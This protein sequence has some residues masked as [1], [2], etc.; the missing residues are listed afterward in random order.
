MGENEISEIIHYT[1]FF[2]LILI[3]NV[4][5][6]GA[7]QISQVQSVEHN[8]EATLSKNGGYTTNSI[9]HITGTNAYSSATPKADLLPINDTKWLYISYD[10]ATDA[11]NWIAYN[12][13]NPQTTANNTNH[14]NLTGSTVE[15]ENTIIPYK[16][17]I[18]P[19]GSDKKSL[20]FGWFPEL[21]FKGTAQSQVYTGSVV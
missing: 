8:V 14:W 1:L 7:L 12:R 10:Y 21:S 15:K 18:K 3:L 16:I 13:T 20:I 6:I 5:F 4:I 17:V 11:R 9:T 2:I 19:L